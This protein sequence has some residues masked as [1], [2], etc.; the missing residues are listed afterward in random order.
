[1]RDYGAIPYADWIS[2]ALVDDVTDAYQPIVT[3][4]EQDV[5]EIDEEILYMHRAAVV[6]S[7]KQNAQQN[8]KPAAP[9]PRRRRRHPRKGWRAWRI[10]RWLQGIFDMFYAI[11]SFIFFC[12][13]FVLF[14]AWKNI[15][16]D[17]FFA[18][19]DNCA[20]DSDCEDSDDEGKKSSSTDDGN[21]ASAGAEVLRRVGETRKDVMTLYRLLG[22]KADVV[23]SFAKRCNEVSRVGAPR[24]DI[25]MYLSDIHDH[26]VTMSGNLT[27]YER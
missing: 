1:L 12:L 15:L 13:Y 11:F 3:Q 9:A 24:A 17:L 14:K 18:S 22:A 21:S 4:T 2:Y 8:G 16:D 5:D 7:T 10:W 6:D 27:H 23:K 19:P 25:G 20:H 26:V